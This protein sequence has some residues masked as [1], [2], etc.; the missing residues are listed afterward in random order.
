MKAVSI[1]SNQA[2]TTGKLW[3][4]ADIISVLRSAQVLDE[5]LFARYLSALPGADA[6]YDES[7]I[8]LVCID[9]RA[10]AQNGLF[11]ALKGARH[12]GHDYLEPVAKLGTRFAL[13]SR[14]AN[15]AI[16]D[17]LVGLAQNYGFLG[18]P[19]IDPLSALQLLAKHYL[20]GLP[21]IT[22]IGVTGSSG[23]TTT[24][25]LLL[26]ALG[27]SKRVFASKGNLN[28]IIGLPL[29]ALALDASYE[30]AIF[31][32]AMSEKG[33]MAV[34]ADIVS[35]DLAVITNIGL[36]HIG[37]IGSQEGIAYE[38]KQISSRFDGRQTVC[39]PETDAWS[40]YLADGVKGTV[41]RYGEKSLSGYEGFASWKSGQIVQW[42]GQSIHLRLP[43]A[44]NRLDALA[45]ILVADRL[46]LSPKAICEG[47]ESFVPGFGRSEI[48][49]GGVTLVQDCYNA[50]P[51]SMKASIAA[52]A[53]MDKAAGSSVMILGDMLE[54]G[55]ESKL[56]HA[57][58][59]EFAA[60][61]GVDVILF[62]G[63]EMQ[64]AFEAATEIE[65]TENQ[66][67]DH[68]LHVAWFS[69]RGQLSAAISDYVD[70]GDLVLLKASRGMEMEQLSP[71]LLA[72]QAVTGDTGSL[73][74]EEALDPELLS[75]YLVTDDDEE[76][77]A[78]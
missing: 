40:D 37:N 44:H 61:S 50:N 32:M 19:V 14:Q 43:G 59:G 36:A 54:L 16:V 18:L 64:A 57:E 6:T 31:E 70:Y 30:L 65:T 55:A 33:E 78:P 52:F 46:G 9:S 56:R 5:V 77:S 17:T 76:S 34:L 1:L 29:A 69:T 53:D 51:D 42:K 7:E 62:C 13:V 22:R 63:Q 47:L 11:V 39:L 12:D 66:K 67:N 21:S 10:A 35:P 48:L 60:R 2:C 27:K 28:S 20:A 58:I 71:Q 72:L 73:P 4:L 41:V 38:K 3:K 8:S 68:I 49:E 26:A 15:Q 75:R 25:D 45:A 74:E 24:K 23:K